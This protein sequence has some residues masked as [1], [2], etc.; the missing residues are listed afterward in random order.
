MV[1]PAPKP[2]PKTSERWKNIRGTNDELRGINEMCRGME[3][4]KYERTRVIKKVTQSEGLRWLLNL[5][6]AQRYREIARTIKAPD[7]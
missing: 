6:Q 5:D 1:M 4:E 2:K 7:L 3:I